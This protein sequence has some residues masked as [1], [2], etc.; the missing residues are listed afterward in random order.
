MNQHNSIRTI[1]T[2]RF[3]VLVCLM[4]LLLLSGCGEDASIKRGKGLL[5]AGD[6]Q[7]AATY[8][9]QLLT[10][11]PEN[12]EV[13]YQLGLAYLQLGQHTEAI[14]PLRTA[15]R[16]AP[17]RRDVQLALGEAY[18]AAGHDRFAL[19]SFLKILQNS[20]H[21]DWV[22]KIG[23]LTGDTYQSIRLT[24]DF[25]QI[26]DVSTAAD[27][28]AFTAFVDDNNEIYVMDIADINGENRQ[29]LTFNDTSDYNPAL[30]PDGKKSLT[31]L[32][33]VGTTPTT[34]FSS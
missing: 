26:H 30:S 18:M 22:Q 6:Y 34:K 25:V 7:G 23:K 3:T 13:H 11:Q 32:L 12:I 28:V 2:S 21:E 31:F 17:Q 9:Q 16:Y 5:A 10:V 27:T 33:S 8:F 29:R 4:F 14:E 24:P 1:Y 15:A 19:S 20:Q